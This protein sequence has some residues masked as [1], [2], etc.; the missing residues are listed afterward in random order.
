M[1]L[2]D[3]GGNGGLQTSVDVG[4]KFR[5]P[6]A[7]PNV[8]VSPT[9]PTPPD[10]GGGSANVRSGRILAA[11]TGHVLWLQGRARLANDGDGGDNDDDRPTAVFSDG[12]FWS[13]PTRLTLPSSEY[14]SPRLFADE[15]LVCLYS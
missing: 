13:P 8:H 1:R 11:E 10:S 6:L 2:E 9:P 15:T 4:D 12:A 14:A 3:R 5:S 7:A